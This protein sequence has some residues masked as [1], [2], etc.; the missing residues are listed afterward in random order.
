[1]PAQSILQPGDGGCESRWF[2]DAECIRADCL[3]ATELDG[4]REK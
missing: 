2:R 1:M 3:K 4:T